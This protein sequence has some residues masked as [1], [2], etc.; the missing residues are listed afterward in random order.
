MSQYENKDSRPSW[1]NK[2]AD[3]VTEIEE[4]KL[5]VKQQT[6]SSQQPSINVD[7]ISQKRKNFKEKKGTTVLQNNLRF[8][9]KHLKYAVDSLPIWVLSNGGSTKVL[10]TDELVSELNKDAIEFEALLRPIDIFKFKDREPFFQIKLFD[11]NTNIDKGLVLY[12]NQDILNSVR[13]ADKDT[14]SKLGAAKEKLFEIEK[15]YDSNKQYLSSLKHNFTNDM[16]L[17]LYNATRPVFAHEDKDSKEEDSQEN[18][19]IQEES[20][21]VKELVTKV[22]KENEEDEWAE[23]VSGKLKEKKIKSQPQNNQPQAK[24]KPLKLTESTL[25]PKSAASTKNATTKSKIEIKSDKPKDD[26]DLL[27]K[28]NPKNKVKKVRQQD[29]DEQFNEVV[30]QES[31]QNDDTKMTKVESQKE[32]GFVSVQS[33]KKKK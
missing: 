28:L 9:K 20:T 3:Q 31:P 16:D 32:E 4:S 25:L 14:F 18:S 30:Q 13:A 5:V 1:R 27:Q 15:L 24:T 19:E 8:I 26:F 2:Q 23:V 22:S 6:E 12:E 11:L 7:E 10:S 17:I 21:Q 33:K 29:F